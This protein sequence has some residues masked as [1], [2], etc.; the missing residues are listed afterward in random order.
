M[1]AD[2]AL[3]GAAADQREGMHRAAARALGEPTPMSMSAASSMFTLQSR[4]CSDVSSRVQSAI[5]ELRSHIGIGAE[6]TL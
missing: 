6:H 2:T 5:D 1:G 4:A 3:P